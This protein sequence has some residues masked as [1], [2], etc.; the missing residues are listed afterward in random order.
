[1]GNMLSALKI[2]LRI[3][4]ESFLLLILEISISVLMVVSITSLGVRESCSR[5]S[6]L[7]SS[8]VKIEK[9]TTL[10]RERED[11]LDLWFG[12]GNSPRRFHSACRPTVIG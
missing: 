11:R 1:M 12:S 4:I 9:A 5:R 8:I 3:Q 6:D 7:G 2:K 10:L